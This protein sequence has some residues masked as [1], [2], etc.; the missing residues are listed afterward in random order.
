[1]KRVVILIVLVAVAGLAGVVVRSSSGSHGIK[2]LVSHDASG[3]DVREEIRKSFELA[4]GAHV[5]LSGLNGSV[6]VETSDSKTAEVYIE[7]TG[8]SPEA[9]ERR[10]VTVEGDANSLRIHGERG[11]GGFFARFFGSKA[12]ERVTLKLPREIALYAKGV[13]G[14][15]TVGELDGPVDVRGVNGRVEIGATT[16]TADF[17]GV[18]GNIVVG[19]RKLDSA[20]VSLNGIN[21]NIELQLATDLNAD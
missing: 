7:R 14:S 11:N 21:G 16:G 9:L 6:T 1:M 18:N 13:N 4:P 12:S 15:V 8:N 5:E 3:G 19:V 10:K 20:G 17:K 2:G